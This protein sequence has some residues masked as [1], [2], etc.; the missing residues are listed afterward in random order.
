M[1][2]AHTN[3]Q[4]T[5]QL[6]ILFCIVLFEYSLFIFSGVSFSFLYGNDFFDLGADP[7]SW[8][9]FG[10]KI[11]Q[12]ITTHHWVGLLLDTCV[13]LLLLLFIR[14]PHKN[15]I[16]KILMLLLFLYYI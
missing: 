8:I 15:R 2:A 14:D 10:L 1:I 5:A 9:I 7:A 3:K 11:P 16:A 12:F 13:I 4:F 6:R